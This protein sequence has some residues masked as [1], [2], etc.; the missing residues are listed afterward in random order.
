MANLRDLTLAQLTKRSMEGDIEARTL[1]IE[2]PATMRLLDRVSEWAYRRYKQDPD[3]I[4][5][6]I[7]VKLFNSINTLKDPS[8]LK[9]WCYGLARNHCLNQIRHLNVEEKYQELKLAEEQGRFGKWHGKPLIPPHLASS[10]EEELLIKEQGQQEELVI[11]ELRLHV[12]EMLVRLEQVFP[13]SSLMEAWTEG[14]TLKQISV[15][16]GLPIA[17]VARQLKKMQKAI[18]TEFL[19]EIETIRGQM[20][21]SQAVIEDEKMIT[22]YILEGLRAK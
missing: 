20:Q 12:R 10:P 17:T 5:D 19:S 9:E 11:E 1:L 13:D 4:K 18:V 3:E 21:S 15:E 2:H 8:R 7:L 14:K 16:K 6:F 22:R